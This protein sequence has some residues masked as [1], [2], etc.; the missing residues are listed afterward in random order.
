MA[1]AV[2]SFAMGDIG[3]LLL[4][5]PGLILLTVWAVVVPSL[6]IDKA[7][8]FGSFSRSADLTRLIQTRFDREADSRQWSTGNISPQRG[9]LINNLLFIYYR[10]KGRTNSKLRFPK[11]NVSTNQAIHRKGRP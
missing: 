8:I 3:F 7:G 6:V 9:N 5:I 2:P 11:T 4:I 10:N 1:A